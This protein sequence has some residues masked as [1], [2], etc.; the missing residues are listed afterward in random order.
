MRVAE[1]I[2]LICFVFLI[3][4]SWLRPMEWRRRAKVHG[5]GLLGF[6]L[7]WL[8]KSSPALLSASASSVLRDWLPAALLLMPYWQAGQFFTKPDEALQDRLERLD[9]K[10]LGSLLVGT[11]SP[12]T[13][14]WMLGYFELVYLLCYPLVPL[15]LGA[16]YLM[17]IE[18]YAD[19]FWTAVLPPAYLCYVL[20]PFFPALPPRMLA[21]TASPNR[22]PGRLRRFN[23]W[24]LRQAS[25][26]ANVFPSAHVAATMAVSLALLRFSVPVGLLFLFVSLSIAVGAVVCRYHYAIDSVVG[27]GLALAGFLLVS[28]GVI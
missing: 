11:G 20:V 7:I 21:E 22:K 3:G 8:A 4:L 15:G 28:Y 12:G 10:W 16:L 13:R 25:I 1:W 27:A 5:I 9:R 2:N 18:L 24:I 19:R 26:T 14:A 6:V 17:G 23:L